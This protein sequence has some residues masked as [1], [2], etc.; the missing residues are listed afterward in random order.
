MAIIHRAVKAALST[1][2]ASEWNDTHDIEEG[3]SF[4][5]TPVEKELFYRIDLHIM[6]CW[7]G[8]IWQALF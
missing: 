8:T 6:Y 1:G 7:D 2:L 3:T 5:V 4:P